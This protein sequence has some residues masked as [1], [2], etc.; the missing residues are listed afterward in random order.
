MKSGFFFTVLAVAC[1]F[2]AIAFAEPAPDTLIGKVQIRNAVKLDSQAKKEI[3]AIAVK[4]KKSLKSGTVKLVGDVSSAESP[5]DYL[6]KSFL[7]AKLVEV[8]LKPLLPGQYQVYLTASRYNGEQS[9]ENNNVS[10]LLYPYE[11]K[12]EGL[13]FI[14]SQLKKTENAANTTN[15]TNTTDEVAPATPPPP[16]EPAPAESSLS[17]P[18]S[19]DYDRS[20][21]KSKKERE[22]VESEDAVQANELVNRA[23]ARAAERARRR[24]SQD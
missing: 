24:E 10:V 22:V 12:A 18:L 1:F 5:E 14:S 9:V 6:T 20:S 17:P 7:L 13:N 16:A 3:A 23:K 19:S 8:Q 4:I 11:L 15:T 2:A 21:V